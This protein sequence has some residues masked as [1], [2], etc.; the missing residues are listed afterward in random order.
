MPIKGT[1]QSV[2]LP[3]WDSHYFKHRATVPQLEPHQDHQ[4]L[5]FATIF[6][7]SIGFCLR[8]ETCHFPNNRQRDHVQHWRHNLLPP[9]TQKKHIRQYLI[10]VPDK[11]YPLYKCLMLLSPANSTSPL[12]TQPTHNTPV[13]PLNQIAREKTQNSRVITL[14]YRPYS[15]PQSNRTEPTPSHISRR[16]NLTQSTITPHILPENTHQSPLAIQQDTPPLLNQRPTTENSRQEPQHDLLAKADFSVYLASPTP[17][18]TQKLENWIC[19][20]LENDGFL[21]LCE[22]VEGIWRRFAL[23]KWV[24]LCF[25]YNIRPVLACLMAELHRAC[26]RLKS[27]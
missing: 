20:N 19:G 17:E 6:R 5:Q 21:Q 24:F 9:H 2:L 4:Q 1:I 15:Q 16:P 23:G 12:A 27:V 8:K 10:Q 22:D 3:L 25:L 13:L 18:R 14:K 7:L 11:S 26:A